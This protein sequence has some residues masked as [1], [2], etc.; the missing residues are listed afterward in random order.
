[1]SVIYKT[2]C[3]INNKIY[4]GQSKYNRDSYLGSGRLIL[5]AIRKYGRDNFTKEVLIE[6]NLTKEELDNLEI[7]FINEYK[8]T[9]SS[10]GY[11]IESGGHGNS[12]LQDS[13]ISESNKGRIISLETKV[14]ISN[15]KIG[16]KASNKTKDTI[17]KS[18]IGN[19]NRLGKY[20]S[21][22]NRVKISDGVKKY[23][24][25]DDNRYKAKE[26]AKKRYD[27]GK[28]SGIVMT[29]ERQIYATECARMTNSKKIILINIE[30]DERIEFES[31]NSC[32]LF[33]GI[34]G[35]SQLILCLK[36]LKLYK[37]KYRIEY[38]NSINNESYKGI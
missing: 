34:K 38:K 24:N 31:L 20:H 19:K 33:F 35:T 18:K 26:I 22:D 21:N 15:S 37:K 3:L 25:N 5:K 23:Y 28:C 6:D 32:R 9:D 13:K 1:M 12:Y 4:I 10:I 27:D 29:K 17:S 2:T 14:K 36:K 7:H 16:K 11:N 30:S 8:S